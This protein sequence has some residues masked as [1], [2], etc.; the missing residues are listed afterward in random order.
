MLVLSFLTLTVGIVPVTFL[1]DIAV[2]NEVSADVIETP[3]SAYENEATTPRLGAS[4]K[5]NPE[6]SWGYSTD[7][8][9]WIDFRDLLAP[10]RGFATDVKTKETP[11][12][13][14]VGSGLSVDYE[15]E[16]TKIRIIVTIGSYSLIS[17]V[18][19]EGDY[20]AVV[21]P[22]MQISSQ[23]GEPALPYRSVF[24]SLPDGV[25]LSSLSVTSRDT[26]TLRGLRVIPGPKPLAVGTEVFGYEEIF[27]NPS[28]YETNHFAPA[29]QIN[30]EV[31]SY[32]SQ[33][34]LLL[35]V[36]PL[37]FNPLDHQGLLTTRM[38]IEIDLTGPVSPDVF[39][40]ITEA[41]NP[42]PSAGEDYVIVTDESFSVSLQYFI[43]WKTT[44]GFNVSLVTVQDILS[45]YSGRDNP[46]KVRN[47]IKDA[48]LTN[49]S[50][51][52]FLVGDGDIVP[53]REVE[54]PYDAG[55]GLDN[56]T[57]PS[58][59][60]YECLDGDWDQNGNDI[61]GESSDNVDLF[62]EVML[63][64][65][66]VQTPSEA[67]EVCASIIRLE[68]DPVPGEWMNNFLLLANDCFGVPGDGPSMVEGYINQQFLYN[69]FFDVNRLIS[70]DGSLSNAAV[71]DAINDGAMIVDFFDHGAYDV[72][73]GAL[74]ATEASNLLNGNM[75]LFAF[76][77]ACETA[78]FDHEAG[79]PTIA[80]AFF[81]NSNGGASIYI[82]ATRIAWAGYHCFD[83][84]HHR[85]WHNF[86]PD[87]INERIASPKAAF[88]AALY[89]MATVFDTSDYTTLETIYQAIYFGDPA[90]N[91]YWKHN[92]TVE[93]SAVEP[94]DTVDLDGTFSLH[95]SNDA[96]VF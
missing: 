65:I 3:Q 78:A 6:K 1:P 94:G 42:T 44:L 84:F 79:E 59:L 45:R 96:I 25:E 46:E 35:R 53:V 29:D 36:Y 20:Q 5:E 22:E 21:V 32:G 71:I 38:E 74:S 17:Y 51:Y 49:G 24:F 90:M 73:S 4:N 85:F 64:R 60:Y 50:I 47:F 63:G 87:A 10:Y 72:W 61:F 88:H 43:D 11:F 9:D 37:Q 89:E 83:G 92:V 86:L 15:I 82:G 39:S 26:T 18:F 48:Y 80:E 62:P 76:A 33:E 75:S 57:E 16:E 40:E 69:S 2:A 52:F 95:V 66:P 8:G 56:G 14:D 93:A 27:A 28:V 31:V 58:D 19:D 70:T 55:L 12:F 13:K 68:S 67:R 23:Y 54:D 91:L 81:R 77:M 7:E 34:I 30:F 41:P